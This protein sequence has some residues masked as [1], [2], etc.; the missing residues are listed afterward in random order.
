M[1]L[2]KCGHT[3]SVLL[4]KTKITISY[5]ILQLKLTTSFKG[6]LKTMFELTYFLG[7]SVILV[8]PNDNK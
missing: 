5:P 1:N 2:Y 8:N 3:F 4:V 6:C 7:G